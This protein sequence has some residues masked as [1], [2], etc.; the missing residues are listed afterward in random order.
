[1]LRARAIVAAA[2][3]CL[4]AVAQPASPGCWIRDIAASGGAVALL[5]GEGV[6]IRSTDGG[7]SWSSLPVAEAIDA[8]AVALVGSQRVVVAGGAGLILISDD[9]GRSWRRPPS[10]AAS[11]LN[12]LTF[13]GL[14]GWAVGAD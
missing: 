11:A 4:P 8:R 9:G 12:D 14:H 2:A 3:T 6:L 7:A 5:C 10:P 1:M 13:V